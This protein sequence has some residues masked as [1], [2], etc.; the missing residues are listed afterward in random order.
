MLTIA[1]R[2]APQPP[3]VRPIEKGNCLFS[4]CFL[5]P[6]LFPFLSLNAPE[7]SLVEGFRRWRKFFVFVKMGNSEYSMEVMHIST[8]RK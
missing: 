6:L 3:M 1:D 7:L 2:F 4:C 5:S 8:C